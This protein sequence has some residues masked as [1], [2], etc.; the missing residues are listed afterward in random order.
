MKICVLKYF[1]YSKV[2][3]NK[4][5]SLYKSNYSFILFYYKNLDEQILNNYSEYIK[6][7]I[8]YVIDFEFL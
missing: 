4:S 8:K 3:I 6:L 1:F 2:I 5:N 7:L